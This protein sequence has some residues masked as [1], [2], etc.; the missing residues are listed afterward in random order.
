MTLII[1]WTDLG[2]TGKQGV[3]PWQVLGVC[4]GAGC[5][6]P[7]AARLCCRLQPKRQLVSRWPLIPAH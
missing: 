6:R 3:E 2:W 7:L 5:Q 4:A 1:D